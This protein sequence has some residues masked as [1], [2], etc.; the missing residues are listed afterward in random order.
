VSGLPRSQVVVV[1]VGARA[2]TGLS[3]LQVT[4]AARAHKMRPRE[5][6]ILHKDGTPIGLCR[7]GSISD[8][9]FGLERFAALGAPSLVQACYPWADTQRTRLGHVPPLAV[10]LA[11]PSA[12]RPGFDPRLKKDLLTLLE[13]RTSIALSH[14]R[15]ELVTECR[16]GGVRVFERAFERLASGQDEAL[17]V[18]GIDSYF[19]PDV[20][21]WLDREFRLHGPD[22]ENGFI[23]GEAAAFVLLTTRARAANL[24]SLAQI[25]GASVTLEPRPFGSEEPCHALGMTLAIKNASG[26]FGTGARRI[27]WVLS[28][29]ADERHR[30]DEWY[31][32]HLRHFQAFSPDFRHEQPLLK[33]GD[34][35]AASAPLLLV[36]AAVGWK[37]GSAHGDCALIAAHSDGPERGALC[38]SVA[39]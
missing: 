34:V 37:I 24:E 14:Q 18:G 5:S 8:A 3:A 25:L 13:A 23:P 2:H 30:V 10:L 31:R 16:A 21:E 9:T 4:L 35:G 29:V 27:P 26:A 32:A 28:D 12:E 22:A 6:H 36:M 17:L 19:D 7:L 1:G 20:L 33:T 39:A 11:L 38:A 15:S